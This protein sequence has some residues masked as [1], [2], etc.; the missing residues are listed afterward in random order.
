M[1]WENWFYSIGVFGC[2]FCWGD[3][4]EEE[5]EEEDDVRGGCVCVCVCVCVVLLLLL[6]KRFVIYWSHLSLTHS[7]QQ[8]PTEMVK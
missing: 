7:T 3:K 2:G 5:A 1:G 8:S 6:L 4:E